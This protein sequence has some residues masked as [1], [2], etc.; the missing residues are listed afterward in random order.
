MTAALLSIGN[1]LEILGYLL[2][3]SSS[4]EDPY[5]LFSA[6]VYLHAFRAGPLHG[7]LLP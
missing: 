3:A 4:Q 2:S 6:S 5:G 1:T 7:C